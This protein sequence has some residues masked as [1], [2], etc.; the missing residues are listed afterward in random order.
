MDKKKRRADRKLAELIKLR[1]LWDTVQIKDNY[2]GRAQRLIVQKI[3]KNKFR[4]EEVE[5]L[6]WDQYLVSIPWQVIAS[7]H[8][9][10]AGLSFEHNLH[11]GQAWN[12]KTTWVPKGRGPFSSWEE[13][14]MDA[15]QLKKETF[16]DAWTIEKTLDFLEKY[17]GLGYRNYHPEVKTPYLWSGTNHYST[18][19]YIADGRWDPTA[20][21]KQLGAVLILKGLFYNGRS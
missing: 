14:A 11:N 13:A 3:N 18:G 4:Y 9:M 8:A 2:W 16:P 19:K 12:I 10:E 6:V 1:D 20:E 15:L 21:S 17:N 7:I 5:K